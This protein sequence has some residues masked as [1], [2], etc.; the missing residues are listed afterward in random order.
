MKRSSEMKLRELKGEIQESAKNLFGEKAY[1]ITSD[2]IPV[3]D[4][5]AIVDRFEKE[6]RREFETVLSKAKTCGP[7]QLKEVVQRI[8]ADLLA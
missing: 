7:E 5:L 6:W 2:W 4:V 3:T 8:I 1:P